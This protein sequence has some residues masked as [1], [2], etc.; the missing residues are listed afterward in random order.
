MK[1]TFRVLLGCWL[2][3]FPVQSYAWGFEG[4]RI[5]AAIALSYL[6]PSVRSNVEAL[7]AADPDT[8]TPSD[9]MSRATWADAWRGSGHR[10]TSEWHFADIE[11]DGPDLAAACNG[12]PTPF[13]L[14]SQGPA[15][16]CVIDRIGAFA[17]ELRNPQT[18]QAERILA[19]K[20]LLHFVGD[21]HQPL[22]S[23]DNHDRGGNC[24]LVSLGGPR[25]VNLHSYWDTTVVE[26]L[27]RNPADVARQLRARVTPA[28]E[29]AW[30]SGDPK[31]WA[32]ESYEVSR[33]SVYRLGSKPGC[34]RDAAAVTLPTAYAEN[35]QAVAAQQLQ[36]AGVRL[37]AILNHALAT[38][39]K[40]QPTTSSSNVKAI[41]APIPDGRSPRSIECSLQADAHGFHGRERQSFRRRCMRS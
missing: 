39:P 23:S 4:H 5:V 13:P 12:F 10:E 15:K 20:Y 37:A 27:G 30:Q 14:A 41:P 24:V 18:P 1:R 11:L 21:I 9:L 28:Q 19:L 32:M 26:A 29:A 17:A 22:H 8:L 31:S 6:Q 38:M 35:A 40:I 7:L 33:V 34:D 36:R 25:T 3:A 2:L 16:D